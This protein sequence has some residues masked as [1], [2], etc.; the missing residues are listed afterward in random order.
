MTAL[1]TVAPEI[2]RDRYG[3][4]LVVPPNGGKPIPY[5]RCTTYID[6]IEDKYGLQQWMQRMVA[7]GLA[8]RPDLLLA[9]SSHRDD[10]KA[11]NKICDDARE[12]AGATAA[13]TTGTALHALTELIDRGQDL[14]TLPAQTMA[15]L[16]AYR[17]ATADLKA[18]HIEQFCVLDT[19]QIGGTPDRVVEYQ[20]ERYI[21]DL[22]TGSIE[23]GALKIA[24][25]LAVYSRSLTYDIATGERGHHG[26]DMT[27]G[28]VIHAPAGQ[29]TAS[30]HWVD[31][32]LG[33]YAVNV[34]TQV[35]EQRRLK[36]RDLMEPFGPYASAAPGTAPGNT[37][38]RRAR[39]AREQAAAE[40]TIVDRIRACTT[41]DEVRALW[42]EDWTSDLNDFAKKHIA[43]IEAA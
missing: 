36:F 26:A 22:K 38:M 5:T 4:P 3:R 28:I 43:D 19:L 6:A 1:D 9:V 17:A 23:Y 20:G 32:E 14:P 29:G 7:L 34:A 2:G 35:R 15:D 24:A 40:P 42:T 31:L 27:R 11:L 18:V 13:A 8:D 37:A 16:D 25:Q 33:W 21:A 30:L 12:A 39:A 10:K 41:A